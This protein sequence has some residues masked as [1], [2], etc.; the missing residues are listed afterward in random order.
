MNPPVIGI[1]ATIGPDPSSDEREVYFVGKPYVDAV[2]AAGGLPVI[3]AH[4][5]DGAAC[6]T[7][8]DGWLIIGGNDLDP[9]LYGQVRHPETKVEPDTR[10]A[11]EKALYGSVPVGMPVLGICYGC[12]LIS[13]L[14]GGDLIQHLPD[15]TG[16]RGHSGGTVQN[17][18]IE[19]GSRLASLVGSTTVE[20]KSYHHQAVNHPGDGLNVVARGEDGTVEAVEDGCG[21]WIVG[22][23]W[24]PERSLDVAASRSL[25]Q[26]FV[27]EARRY[28][29][30]KTS[31]GTW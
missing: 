14:R 22:V 3:L 2:L 21:A 1:V 5:I 20:G 13:V 9:A 17:Y 18:K 12:Q 31:C 25:F 19:E 24:H 23:Q 15:V 26:G 7:L 28:K 27:D 10:F 4:G 8:I 29:E 11:Q 16:H 6:A 30:S